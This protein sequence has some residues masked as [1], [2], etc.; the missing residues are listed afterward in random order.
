MNTHIIGNKLTNYYYYSIT[1]T[2]YND[3]LQNQEF[4][5]NY[6]TFIISYFLLHHNY[7][8]KLL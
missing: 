8:I 4:N 1:S 3:L 7:Y 6:M 2:T 5:Y